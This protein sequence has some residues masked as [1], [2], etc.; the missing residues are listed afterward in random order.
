M[1]TGQ[2]SP[3]RSF[4]SKVW[5][6]VRA[7]GTATLASGSPVKPE[8]SVGNGAVHGPVV[9]RN[10]ELI[11]RSRNQHKRHGLTLLSVYQIERRLVRTTRWAWKV[12]Q[13]Q[14]RSVYHEKCG[15]RAGCAKRTLSQR[16]GRFQFG[17]RFV[18]RVML[19]ISRA[20]QDDLSRSFADLVS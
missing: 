8:Y 2:A 15:F 7:E 13:Y 16:K 3:H 1:R 18:L 14:R 20:T 9:E 19:G 4:E 12:W 17:C 11:T 6:G 5:K 10:P